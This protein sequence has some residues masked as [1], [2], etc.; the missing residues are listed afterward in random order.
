MS[1]VDINKIDFGEKML[2]LCALRRS[3]FDYVLYKGSG[4]HRL[5]WQKAYQ[6][7]FE[8][9]PRDDDGLSF[10]DICALFNWPPEYIRRL[11]NKLERADLK[12]IETTKFRDEFCDM[13]DS[14][15]IVHVLHWDLTGFSVPF[16]PPSNYADRIQSQLRLRPVPRE[17]SGSFIRP[18]AWAAAL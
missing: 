6:F 15:F 1:W 16:F 13:D 18:G 10:D 9:K 4:R 8:S 3:I 7:I 12:K 11:I 2:W 14:K 17:K 5:Q